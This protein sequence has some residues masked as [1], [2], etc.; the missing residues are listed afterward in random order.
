MRFS[1]WFILF[2]VVFLSFS[3]GSTPELIKAYEKRD[4]ITIDEMIFNG[5]N[6]NIKDDNGETVLFHA[7]RNNDIEM[8][9]Y[10]IKNRAS[11]N[12]SNNETTP[13]LLAVINDYNDIINILLNRGAVIKDNVF[14]EAIKRNNEDAVLRM[15]DKGAN[16]NVKFT[17]GSNLLMIAANS[18]MLDVLKKCVEKGINVNSKDQYNETPLFWAASKLSRSLSKG[19]KKNDAAIAQYLIDNG[20]DVNFVNKRSSDGYYFTVLFR[21]SW[22]DKHDLIKVLLKNGADVNFISNTNAERTPLMVSSYLND[23]QLA[24][25]LLEHKANPNIKTSEGLTA[26]HYAAKS[27]PGEFA[28][29]LIEYGADISIKDKNGQT[30]LAVAKKEKNSAFEKILI[31][32]GDKE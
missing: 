23:Y 30:P 5:Y 9:N 10:L 15:M 31:N 28:E 25:L 14:K 16:I 8:V 32:A 7:V 12:I 18:G 27:C 20:A 2:F 17:N 22:N 1:K 19:T 26:L 21:A 13:L 6:I 11:I 24:K 3:Y 29:L 4:I